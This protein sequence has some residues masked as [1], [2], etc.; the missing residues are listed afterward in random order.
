ML[1]CVEGFKVVD[2]TLGV[3]MVVTLVVK[4]VVAI[5]WDH[6]SINTDIVSML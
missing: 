3:M 1:G 2:I 6:A 4:S 5:I